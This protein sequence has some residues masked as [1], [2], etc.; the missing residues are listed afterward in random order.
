MRAIELAPPWWDEVFNWL[1]RY[2][3]HAPDL[4]DAALVLTSCLVHRLARWLSLQALGSRGARP[5]R[6]DRLRS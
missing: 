5:R 2:A 6:A 1:G 3:E 4:G